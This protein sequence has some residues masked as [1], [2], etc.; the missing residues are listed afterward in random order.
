MRLGFEGGRATARTL[1]KEGDVRYV[2]LSWGGVEPPYTTTTPTGDWCGP[3]ITGST[4]WRAGTF[5]DHP[6]RSYLQRSA[7]TLKGLTYSPTGAIIAAATTSLPET[8][9]GERNYDYRYSWIRDST[10]ALWAMYSLGFDWEAVDFF[11]FIADVASDGRRPAGHVRRRRRTRPGRVRTRPSA[12]LR[13]FAA[14]AHRQRRPLP[15]ASTMSGARCSTRSICTPRATTIVDG[16]IWPMLGKQVAAALKHWREPDQG[17]WE[18]RGRPSTSP[19]PRSSAGSR[20]TAALA[21]PR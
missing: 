2:A 3:P 20:S 9:G 18:V 1:L 15:D 17:I 19:R 13:Q 21:W 4:G 12:R 10:F 16:R 5:P 8:L 6:W 7:L 14:G 11:S